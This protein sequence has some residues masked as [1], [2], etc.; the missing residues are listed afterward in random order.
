MNHHHQST[1]NAIKVIQNYIWVRKGVSI[2]ITPDWTSQEENR[3][4]LVAYGIAS[5]WLRENANQTKEE[6][7]DKKRNWRRRN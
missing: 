7:N 4:F 1:L 5:R 6:E 2:E 3:L